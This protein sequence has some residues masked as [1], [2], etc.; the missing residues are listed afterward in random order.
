MKV[1]SNSLFTYYFKTERK[2]RKVKKK[3]YAFFMHTF[4]NDLLQFIS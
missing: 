3:S 2:F 4:A 1:N